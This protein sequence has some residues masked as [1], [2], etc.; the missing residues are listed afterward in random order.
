MSAQTTQSLKSNIFTLRVL[1]LLVLVAA[2]LV[3]PAKAALA[4]DA[5]GVTEAFTGI[6]TTITDIIQ[7]LAVVVGILGISFWGFGKLARP[8]FPEI[9]Q[10]AGQYIN[11]F[12]IG[13][14]AVY[15]AS[16]VVEALAGAIGGSV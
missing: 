4:Q 9:S 13:L 8:I 10:M 16:N 2:L 5:G 12:M 15:L 14:V 3:L 11:Q 6:V 7:S 1:T